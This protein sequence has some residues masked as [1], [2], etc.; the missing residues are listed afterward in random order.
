MKFLFPNIG[1]VIDYYQITLN[2]GR[3]EINV[4]TTGSVT[5][6]KSMAGIFYF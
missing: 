4:Y 6:K 3:G 5:K 2:S 1:V